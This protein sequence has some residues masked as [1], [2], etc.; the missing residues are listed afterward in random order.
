MIV[1]ATLLLAALLFVITMLISI[2]IWACIGWLVIFVLSIFMA[3]PSL[4]FGHYVAI[5]LLLSLFRPIR[6]SK[7]K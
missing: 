3:V 5:G 7:T 2:T 4:T 1:F 6:V